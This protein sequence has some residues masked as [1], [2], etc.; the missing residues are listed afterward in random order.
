MMIFGVIRL[1]ICVL[2]V[3]L[4]CSNGYDGLDRKPVRLSSIDLVKMV[5]EPLTAIID[6]HLRD[7]L[8]CTEGLVKCRSNKIEPIHRRC[9]F[10][11]IKT[12]LTEELTTHLKLYINYLLDERQIL[13]EPN[14]ANIVKTLDTV[15]R[16]VVVLSGFLA[17]LY[18]H[19]AEIT[20]LMDTYLLL[21]DITTVYHRSSSKENFVEALK[22]KSYEPSETI[23]TAGV[24]RRL[25][26][27]YDNNFSPFT[28]TYYY[29]HQK[30]WMTPKTL[31]WK[32]LMES[33]TDAAELVKQKV[34]VGISELTFKQWYDQV[35]VASTDSVEVFRFYT[36]V[37]DA[38]TNI[39][40][41]ATTVIIGGFIQLLRLLASNVG[42]SPSQ[43]REHVASAFYKVKDLS[44]AAATFVRY[45]S[46]YYHLIRP[47][48]ELENPFNVLKYALAI[49]LTK[50]NRLTPERMWPMAAN[51][52]KKA[53]N[54]L[55]IHSD[56]SEKRTVTDILDDMQ[57]AS[58]HTQAVIKII[59]PVEL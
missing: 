50:P 41:D 6:A 49:G 56:P 40:L 44:K 25:F 46:D 12:K 51:L 23:P 29:I 28:L 24:H 22:A 39:I 19:G 37:S 7:H 11:L 3:A 31:K 21:S 2:F 38:V 5:P 43:I 53:N 14:D 26:E 33:T 1:L 18:N 47:I 15:Q 59:K 10:D 45:S 42:L 34:A 4:V 52:E 27:K 30:F 54:I 35:I 36:Q 55:Q 20:E 58:V 9:I 32:Q 8:Y 17:F 16:H 48:E 57:K 13:K